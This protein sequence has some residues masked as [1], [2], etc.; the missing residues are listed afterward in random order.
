MEQ[1]GGAEYIQRIQAYMMKALNEAKLTTSWIQPNEEWL[2]ATRD[3][4]A[5]VLV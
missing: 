5:K 1:N 4:V 2:A 3:F